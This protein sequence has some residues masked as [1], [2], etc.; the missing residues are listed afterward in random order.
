MFIKRTCVFLTLKRSIMT[1]RL[2]L[3]V[4][5]KFL[6]SSKQQLLTRRGSG[7]DSGTVPVP[8]VTEVPAL[9]KPSLP[10]V[11]WRYADAIIP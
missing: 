7:H 1:F 9:P 8:A 4:T 11:S 5:Q 3:T 6:K 10:S 2:P